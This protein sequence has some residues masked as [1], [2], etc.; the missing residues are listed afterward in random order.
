MKLAYRL[1]LDDG[2]ELIASGDHRFLST[3]GW[4]YVAAADA[5][6]R[7]PVLT[8][9]DHLVARSRGHHVDDGAGRSFTRVR[10]K[11]ISVLGKRELF[12][13]T[14]GTG[15]FIANGV[16]SHN[17]YARPSHEYLDMGAGTDFDTKIVVKRDAPQLLREA[18]DK[19]SWV[20]ETVMFS[21]VTDCYQAIERELELTRRCLEVCLEYRNPVSIISKSALVE[22]DLDLF[23]ELARHA[24]IA[25]MVSLA[26]TNN[27]LSRSIEPWAAS[28]DRR[29]KV[30]E[31]LAAAG[32]PVGVMCAPIIPGVNDSQLI[33]VL[34]RAAECGAT[35]AGWSLLRLPGV[36][37]QVFEERIRVALPLA[38]DKVLHRIRETRGGEKLYDARFH[39]RGRGEGP[40]AETIATLFDTTVARLGL[41]KR[42]D[43]DGPTTF[44]RP[45]PR[46]GQL[47]LF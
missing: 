41:N 39:T 21:G 3:A 11:S 23:A 25:V 36:V 30:I 20:G 7:R 35:M 12:D 29:F 27:Q 42:E 22:R 31:A 8:T 10:I 16:V 18:F 17:C 6:D 37:K 44:C 32:V 47:S 43:S 19:K 28:P 14:T 34:E 40:Y 5:A 33:G 13:I 15:D 9:D 45:P 24:R 4:K 1:V 46:S 26:F 2:G 38:A